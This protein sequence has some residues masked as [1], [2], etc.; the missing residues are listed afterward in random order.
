MVS[1]Y[2]DDEG[3]VIDNMTIM[4]PPGDSQLV[5]P[6]LVSGRWIQPDDERKLAVSEAILVEFPDFQAGDFLP[7]K[8]NGKTEIWE[9]VG[10]F[11][12]IGMED[13]KEKEA[14]YLTGSSPEASGPFN[15][16]N[17]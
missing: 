16:D 2:L 17:S 15:D 5:S 7:M 4:A 14:L 11:K 1:E 12:F 6:I 13:I 10:I 3:E 9:V 8:V